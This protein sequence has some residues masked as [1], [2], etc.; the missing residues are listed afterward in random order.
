MNK[1]ISKIIGATLAFAMMI[2]VGAVANS[3]EYKEMRA[4]EGETFQLVKD[5]S[6][7]AVDDKV[8]IGSG[9]SGNSVYLLSTT[10]NSN[11]R[12]ATGTFAVS[13]TG[14]V[15]LTSAVQVLTL[16]QKNSHWT[17]NTG[18]GYLY[19]ASSSKNY[20]RTQTTND[21]NGEW[22]I[23]ISST[24]AATVT[25]QGSNTRNKLKYNANNG[26]PIFSAYDSNGT[27]AVYKKVSSSGG[28]QDPVALTNPNPQY[29]DLDKTVSWT[30]D[31]N[32]T[33]YQVKVDDS[34]YADIETAT[35]DARNLSAGDEHTVYIKAVGDGTNYLDAEASVKFTPTP[36]EVHRKFAVKTKTSV[37]ETG[38]AITGA[39]TSFL[40]TYTNTIGQITNGNSM[41]L[42]I[43]GLTKKV[44]INKLV[45]SMHSNPKAGAGSISVKVDSN[46]ASFVAGTANNGVN[47]NQM[48]D[49]T[50]YS[51]TDFVDVTWAGLNYIA[52]SSIEIKISGTVN[53]LYCQSFLVFFT[54][55][56]NNDYVTELTVSPNSWTG[57]TTSLLE[58]ENF[59]VSVTTGG[60]A[61]SAVDYTFLGIGHMDGENFVARDANFIYGYP[62]VGD[63]RLAW[64]ANYPTT[65]GGDTYLYAYVTLNVSEDTIS[66]VVVS[67]TLDKTSY[68]TT[69]SW[70]RYGLKVDAIYQSSAEHTV[71]A[72]AEYSFYS[73]AAMTQEVATPAD[74]GVGENQTVYVKATYEGVSNI[75][76]YAQTVTVTIEPGT[77]ETDPLTPDEAIA[78]GSKFGN[79][80][81][82][83]K[84][85]YIRGTVI[86]VEANQLD[87]E[88]KDKYAT[89]TLEESDE[90]FAFKGYKIQPNENCKNYEDLRNGAV[91]LLKCR[92]KNYLNHTIENGSVGELLSIEYTAQ[93][94]S[95]IVLDKT[96]LILE[97]NE[98]KAL[99]VSP[100]PVGADLGE[101]SWNSSNEQVA[102]VDSNGNVTAIAQGAAVITATA[103]EFEAKCNV[104]VTK[105]RAVDLT[106]DETTSASDDALVWSYSNEFVIE[107]A[108]G[109]GTKVTNYYPGTPN[110][111]YTI[112]RF[113]AKNTIT[114]TPDSKTAVLK[115]LFT[116]STDA[117]TD[118]LAASSFTNATVEKGSKTVIATI[119]NS[120]LPLNV[121][122]GDKCDFTGIKVYYQDLSAEQ[123]VEKLETQSSLAYHYNKDENDVYTYSNISM[124]FGGSISKTL[125]NE[126]DTDEHL[127]AGIGVM[128]TGYEENL[129]STYSIKDHAAE[130]VSYNGD[131]NIKT[132]LV[133]CYVTLNEFGS[134]PEKD[135][136]Y[137]WN[138]KQPI[139]SY[140]DILDDYTAA[141]YIKLTNG[142]LVFM[143][144]VKY[145]VWSLA[146]DYLDN[147]NC[148]EETAGG[149]LYHL[150]NDLGME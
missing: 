117:S 72:A 142:D 124:R 131:Y 144:Q 133:D 64:K 30:K 128:I 24:G 108:K 19:A 68:Y 55:E 147:R 150:Y 80:G 3:R 75:T 6:T 22:A 136:N 20:L 105:S 14:T 116:L 93:P 139:N 120:S 69:D 100:N 11:N 37:T 12:A 122:V 145:S 119:T 99:T 91:V 9:V 32:A 118:K 42:S 31:A 26:S 21:A 71:T 135:N 107:A 17:F 23:S 112:T 94:L 2:G 47:F 104:S 83:Q 143:Q 56:E 38:D 86:D 57:Y 134:M 27:V 16:G 125:W 41:T 148:N 129:R 7:L 101:V 90:Q 18:N 44:T 46:D 78:I 95:G 82:T 58:I 1:F 106:I 87:Q 4:E 149:S 33:K 67:G 10:Q 103:G 88:G 113:Y 25:A 141:A 34:S 89:F 84:E 96:S 98:Q 35:Y 36:Y 97:I 52:K 8:V 54:E 79:N 132:Q 77:Q 62:Q 110:Q 140:D 40:Q 60:V 61:G 5:V 137:Y 50:E 85:Y 127:I 74:L 146:K 39:T 59:T 121:A 123:L 29:D 13:N 45:L 102:T 111:T 115:V 114:V 43:T 92:I 81:E 126:L 138:F 70:E 51:G 48:G 49:N 66:S 63:T 28:Q 73:D 76:G 109:T 15:T 130:A 53:S 65:V